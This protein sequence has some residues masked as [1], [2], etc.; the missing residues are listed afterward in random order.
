MRDSSF[1]SQNF[2]NSFTFILLLLWNRTRLE[3]RGGAD[4]NRGPRSSA[5]VKEDF[6][7]WL[8]HFFIRPILFPALVAGSAHLSFTFILDD[9][10]FIMLLIFCYPRRLPIFE[11]AKST[12]WCLSIKPHGSIFLTWKYQLKQ[13]FTSVDEVKLK[14]ILVDGFGNGNKISPFWTRGLQYF[15]NM[16]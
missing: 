4:S 9:L 16:I 13:I 12:S 15:V 5:S 6:A 11:P 1:F 8:F 14:N 7:T 2:H 10:V 3:V